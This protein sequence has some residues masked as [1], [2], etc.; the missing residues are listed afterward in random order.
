MQREKV[1]NVS[2]S[3][4]TSFLR[5]S[6][7]PTRLKYTGKYLK[8]VIEIIAIGSNGNRNKKENIPYNHL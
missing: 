8:A 5:T 4:P 1:L 3:A 7:K 6:T 2:V